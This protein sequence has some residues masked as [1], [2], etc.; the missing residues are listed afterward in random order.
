MVI[1]LNNMIFMLWL[2]FNMFINFFHGN[3]GV[4]VEDGDNGVGQI[5]EGIG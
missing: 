2:F 3:T 1:K 5:H 4:A